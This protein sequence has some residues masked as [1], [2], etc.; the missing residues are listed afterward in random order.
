MAPV[1]KETRHLIRESVLA[2]EKAIGQVHLAEAWNLLQE[3]NEH[4][5]PMG[6]LPYTDSAVKQFEVA[7]QHFPN[8]FGVI[9]HLAICYHAQAWDLELRGDPAAARRWQ[10][11]LRYWRRLEGAV[12]FWNALKQKFKAIAPEADPGLLDAARR[13]LMEDLLDIH[14]D[15]VQHHCELGCTERACVHTRIVNGARIA[16]A[17]RKRLVAKVFAAMTSSVIEARQAGAFAS[18][19]ESVERFLQLLDDVSYVPAL[20]MHAECCAAWAEK[21]SYQDDWDQIVALSERALPFAT[22]LANDSGLV[23]DSL[24]RVALERLVSKMADQGLLR[25]RGQSVH[26]GGATSMRDRQAALAAVD[27]GLVWARLGRLCG[28]RTT[29]MRRCLAGLLNVRACCL[30]DKIADLT[31]SGMDRCRIELAIDLVEQAVTALEE[32]VISVPDDQV[33]QSN[34][35]AAREEL[36]MLTTRRDILGFD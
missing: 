27:T 2:V 23:E 1:A 4:G 31:R 36:K 21:L 18:A 34:L 17:A 5:D 14:V 3:R 6:P 9:H 25:A 16:P 35:G 13:R 33:L 19:L 11:A 15:F 20:R 10:L 22:R 26:T 24:A 7:E 12:G 32:A 28:A 29:M 30:D 8:D